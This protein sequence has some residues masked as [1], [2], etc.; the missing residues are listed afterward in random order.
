MV[1]ACRC[2]PGATSR[3]D[4]RHFFAVPFPPRRSNYVAGTTYSAR[5]PGVD[6]ARGAA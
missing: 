3:S 1:S 4:W 2:V 6:A 5:T